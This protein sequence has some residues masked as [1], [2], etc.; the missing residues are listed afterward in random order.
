M[1]QPTVME[2]NDE[3]EIIQYF[4]VRL[5]TNKTFVLMILTVHKQLLS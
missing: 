1:A 3:E 4:F 2:A 5:P